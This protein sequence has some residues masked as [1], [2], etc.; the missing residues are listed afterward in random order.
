[1]R[2]VTKDRTLVRELQ[3]S[4]RTS[5]LTLCAMLLLTLTSSGYLL[6]VSQP[7]VTRYTDLVRDARLMHEAMLDQETGL[8]GWLATGDRDFLVPTQLGR[9]QEVAV[10]QQ[11]LERSSFDR[12]ATADLLPV[13]VAQQEWDRWADRAARWRVTAEER[14]GGELTRFLVRGKALFDEYRAAEARSTAYVVQQRD[15]AIVGERVALVLALVATLLMLGAGGVHT[16]LRRRRL[17]RA[18]AQPM[19][20]L[21]ETIHL[22][23]SGDRRT[24]TRPT[25]VQELD[26]IGSA[27]DG[28]TGELVEAEE[29]ATAREVRLALLARRLETVITVARETSG[30]L[31][32]GHVGES[33]TQAAAELLGTPT[34]LWARDDEGVLRTVTSSADPDG[35]LSAADLEPT[36]LVGAV[37][38]DARPGSDGT[39]RAYPLI[40][41]GT[42]VGVLEVGATAAADDDVE[43]VLTALLST[44]A[45]GIESARLHS[46][47]RE[48]AELDALTRLPN[49][50]RLEED[51]AAAWQRSRADSRPC[52]FVMLDLDHF[53]SLNDTHGHPVG[54]SVLR[55]AASALAANLRGDDTAY[56]YGGEEFAVLLRETDL[57]EALGIA[58]RLRSAI[59]AVKVPGRPVRVTASI[60]VATAESGM[61][62]QSAL[63]AAADGALYRAKRGG[64][65]RVEVAGALPT[66]EPVC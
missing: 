37:A 12:R 60:G 49:R 5:V 43:R 65:D 53:K 38:A 11:M 50:R 2:R 64:R 28:F 16:A 30:S 45:A 48:Q 47:A 57:E 24:R 52:T 63:V 1:M 13:L 62:D 35:A 23:R 26:A 44:A 18:I 19:R 9:E 3:D 46:T 36:A 17:E 51:L 27:L 58:E 20:Q 15:R 41:G 22:L 61:S 29:L 56:R 31:S 39:A 14:D 33:V 10:A 66:L 4:H 40:L 32:V 42:V 59:A 34:T 54:D 6:L 8:R 7:A 21:L 25:G 55:S